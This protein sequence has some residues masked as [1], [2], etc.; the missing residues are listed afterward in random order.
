MNY[1][2]QYGVA[3]LVATLA[4]A[5]VVAAAQAEGTT[6]PPR[7]AWG[8]PDLQGVFDYSSITPM[9]RPK[10]YGDQEFLT[11]EEAAAL[12]EGAVERD[13]AAGAAPARPAKAGENVGAYNLFW[14]DLGTKVV[15]D[16]R[17]SRIIDPPNGRFPALT[18]A[19]A[20]EAETRTGF[21]AEMPAD[22]YGDLGWVTGVWPF[23]ASRS[24]P[25]PI[26][27]WSSCFRRLTM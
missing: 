25:F 10:Q 18:E 19:G 17:T 21:G 5:P 14:M 9:Q 20:A 13:R 22:D 6:P 15:E 4:L 2:Q 3:A 23:M 8:A 27:A 16:R 26:T 7:T 12:E 24:V 1:R 11:E